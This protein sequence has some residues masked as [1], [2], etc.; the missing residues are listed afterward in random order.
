MDLAPVAAIVKK[1][2]RLGERP[3]QEFNAAHE[4]KG[5]DT[6]NKHGGGATEWTRIGGSER[7]VAGRKEGGGGLIRRQ[8]D[9]FSHL[10]LQ[11]RTVSFCNNFSQQAAP[12]HLHS[13]AGNKTNTPRFKSNLTK[14][15]LAVC[16]CK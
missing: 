2:K 15:R 7:L 1:N 16:R 3:S 9:L 14:W 11:I 6:Q 8:I 10:V 5:R 13:E 4:R 12:V